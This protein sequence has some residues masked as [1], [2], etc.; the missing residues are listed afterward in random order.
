[1]APKRKDSPEMYEIFQTSLKEKI[2]GYQEQIRQEAT[3]AMPSG[4]GARPATLAT[5]EP[6]RPEPLP[7]EE[8]PPVVEER[9]SRQIQKEVC[10]VEESP[11]AAGPENGETSEAR[12]L[13][14]QVTLSVPTIMAVLMVFLGILFVCYAVGVRRGR[15]LARE[16]YQAHLKAM[17][18]SEGRPVEL[19]NF[20]GTASGIPESIADADSARPTPRTGGA[21]SG[22]AAT[23][24]PWS[25]NLI[26][27]PL[28]NEEQ[29]QQAPFLGNTM[30]ER[31]RGRVR[32]A[33]FVCR[34]F[35]HSGQHRQVLGVF[36]GRFSDRASAEAY[37]QS[38]DFQR[39]FR[40]QFPESQTYVKYLSAR[41]GNR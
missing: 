36:V 20:S 32:H 7:A 13:S 40:G 26:D 8:E 25:V 3:K 38:G 11:P 1:M 10:D 37:E 27:Y 21:E 18:A 33:M 6:I 4:S 24:G 5:S 19:G 31:Y 9:S 41:E 16:E 35:S 14:Q 12:L 39:V 15:S 34:H 2:R 29:R 23:A 22:R 28:E 30:L 17:Q